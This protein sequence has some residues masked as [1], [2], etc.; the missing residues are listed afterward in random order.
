M[1]EDITKYCNSCRHCKLRK[2]D[3]RVPRL[4]LSRYPGVT[5]AFQRVH[6]DLVGPLTKTDSGHEYIL[7]IKDALTQWIE[8]VPLREKSDA[9]W[10]VFQCLY[11]RHGSAEQL[12]SDKGKKFVNKMM[13]AINL[14][15]VQNHI[16][17]I[18]YHPAANG[19]V[20]QQN[21]TLKDM[22]SGYVAANQRNWDK[23]LQVVAHAYRTTYNS[24]TGYSPFRAL[25]GREA[26][27]PSEDWISDFAEL[28]KVDIHEYARELA[29]VLHYTW[30][31]ISEL[32]RKKELKEVNR[33]AYPQPL[34][35][36]VA[37]EYHPY[38]P[39]DTFYLKSIP[40]RF[41]TTEEGERQ[42]ITAKLQYRYTGPHR[43]IGAKNPVTFT[44]MVNGKFKTVHASKMKRES[45][46]LYEEFREVDY[47]EEQI[48]QGEDDLQE[49]LTQLARLV[50]RNNRE[51][52]RLEANEDIEYDENHQVL[53]SF[54]DLA[55]DWDDE[56]DPG[57]TGPNIT[58]SMA[59]V[60]QELLFGGITR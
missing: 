27:Q 38:E 32:I 19:K 17:T 10:E 34:R 53:H 56:Q 4:P 15:L 21:R 54:E 6:I 48:I 5:R 46:V 57:N 9:A 43:V 36:S 25:Y 47:G 49:E 31:E 14:L 60:G 30:A 55:Q 52:E 45:K 23:Y 7:V 1:D 28:N 42:K 13:R 37:L 18:P 40:K 26:R 50:E 12:V 16:S 33:T 29:L 2:A 24:A 8:L 22:L 58:R 51:Q 20:E 35:T 41:F 39:E 59:E 44:A 11:C 3:Y